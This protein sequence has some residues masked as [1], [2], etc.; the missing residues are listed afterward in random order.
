MGNFTL[1]EAVLYAVTVFAIFNFPK[2]YFY[3]IY[4]CVY[5]LHAIFYIS[6]LKW[7]LV[8]VIRW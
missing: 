7:F 3:G 6:T 4:T 2:M 1:L 5:D 8:I